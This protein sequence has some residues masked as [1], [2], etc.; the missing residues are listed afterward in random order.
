V[1][2]RTLWSWVADRPVR[3]TRTDRR[4]AWRRN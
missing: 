2:L 1:V 3:G 4:R